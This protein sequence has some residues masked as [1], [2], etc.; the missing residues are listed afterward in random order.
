MLR[1]LGVIG[2]LA[3]VFV[4]APLAPVPASGQTAGWTAPRTANGQPDIQ[5]IW[6]YRTIT[7]L[8]RAARFGNKQFLT[9]EEAA[10][11]ER[12]KL[13]SDNAPPEERVHSGG[14]FPTGGRTVGSGV[15][16]Q[17]VNSFWFDD[18][19]RYGGRGVIPSRRTS[20][21]V[22]PSDGKIPY[23][24]SQ[25]A[26]ENV[27]PDARTDRRHLLPSGPENL[28]VHAR[29]L[30]FNAGPPILPTAYNNNI[31]IFQTPGHV[32]IFNEMI[33][34]TRVIPLDGRPHL[35]PRVRQW[36]GDSRGRWEGETLVVET[37]NYNG[38]EKF[39]L[40]RATDEMHLV[41]RFTRVGPDTLHYEFTV[42]DPDSYSSPW[43]VAFP[44]AKSSL[45]VYE[46]ACHEGNYGI[47]NILAGAR[48]DERAVEAAGLVREGYVLRAKRY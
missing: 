48:A 9:E 5:G 43:T 35:D 20:L 17:S 46:Y 11:L 41:E 23:R 42:F 44:M 32:V 37:T 31:Q 8:E 25:A 12:E 18:G 4:V 3:I 7:T 47:V 40:P 34:E 30:Q 6:D 10:A 38:H 16:Q 14:A 22:Y 24:Q 1:S 28:N 39:M 13:D 33:H 2:T 19:I 26:G 27:S 21:L 15:D 29:C 36:I 45:A